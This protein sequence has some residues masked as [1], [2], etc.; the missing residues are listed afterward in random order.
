MHI[1]ILH[2]DSPLLTSSHIRFICIY[3]YTHRAWIS[4]PPQNPLNVTYRH[5]NI[6][7]LNTLEYTYLWNTRTLPY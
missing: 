3:M 5:S 6:L 7:T 4:P 1:Y 2:L